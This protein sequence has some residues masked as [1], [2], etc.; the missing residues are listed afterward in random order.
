MNLLEVIFTSLE[1]YR[2]TKQCTKVVIFVKYFSTPKMVIYDLKGALQHFGS[3]IKK[4][5]TT[6]EMETAIQ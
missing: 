3:Q 4:A 2:C 5:R 6:L 1:R